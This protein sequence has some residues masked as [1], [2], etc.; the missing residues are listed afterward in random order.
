MC[1]GFAAG[2]SGPKD[3][4]LLDCTGPQSILVAHTKVQD[5][6]TVR[7]A[8]IFAGGF[9]GWSQA[10]VAM[11]HSHFSLRLPGPL[12]LMLSVNLPRPASTPIPVWFHPL[13]PCARLLRPAVSRYASVPMPTIPGGMQP[14][15]HL[16]SRW[17]PTLVLS[18]EGIRSHEPGRTPPGAFGTRVWFESCASHCD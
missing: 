8:E 18:R 11:R 7:I 12:R 9:M 16:P 2:F 13:Q 5:D 4:R 3:I 10:C 1:A 17:S 6:T 15:W 14:S